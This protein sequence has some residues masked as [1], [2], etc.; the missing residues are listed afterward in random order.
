V[1]ERVLVLVEGAVL[2]E[3]EPAAVRH[4]QRVVQAYLGGARDA[5]PRQVEAVRC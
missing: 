1:S 2:M 5:G 4:D 3:G